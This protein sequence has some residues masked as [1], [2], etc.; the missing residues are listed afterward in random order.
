MPWLPC[1]PEISQLYFL[2]GAD[3][4]TPIKNNVYFSKAARL[5]HLKASV[6]D[7]CRV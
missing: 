7:D 5:K 6:S 3:D 1:S 2:S 4:Y